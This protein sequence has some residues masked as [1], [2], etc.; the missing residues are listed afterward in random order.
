MTVDGYI[1][2]P[3]ENISGYV[4]EGTGLDQYLDDLKKYV[5]DKMQKAIDNY[6]SNEYKR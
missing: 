4:N 2:G 3:N 6:Q 1:A 5:I